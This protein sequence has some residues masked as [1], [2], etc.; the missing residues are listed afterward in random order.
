MRGGGCFAFEFR[1]T[2]VVRQTADPDT[3]MCSE[4]NLV[5]LSEH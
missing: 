5:G 4:T 3:L 2:H 1:N